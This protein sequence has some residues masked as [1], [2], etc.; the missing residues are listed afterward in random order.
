MCAQGEAAVYV[1]AV[2]SREGPQVGFSPA[3]LAQRVRA[4]LQDSSP[5]P[6]PDSWRS[7]LS[8]VLINIDVYPRLSNA[9]NEFPSPDLVRFECLLEDHPE[10][11]IV[12]R[13]WAETLDRDL[14]VTVAEGLLFEFHASM[15][16]LAFAKHLDWR[17]RYLKTIHVI[18]SRTAIA[19]HDYAREVNWRRPIL[20]VSILKMA[21]RYHRGLVMAESLTFVEHRKEFSGRLGVASVLISRFESISKDDAKEAV[22]ALKRSIDQ[23]NDPTLAT[24]YLLEALC[25]SY[26]LTGDKHILEEALLFVDTEAQRASRN[27]DWHLAAVEILLRLHD[28]ATTTERRSDLLASAQRMLAVSRSFTVE[29]EEKLRW[30]VL[31]QIVVT[32]NRRG[33]DLGVRGTRFPF[34]FRYTS[35]NVHVVS[36]IITDLIRVVS[37]LAREGE[38]LARG[39]YA[40]LIEQA[41]QLGGSE[42]T[43][44]RLLIEMR[45]SSDRWSA[46]QDERSLLLTARDRLRLARLTRD[47]KLRTRALGD[48]VELCE[49]PTCGIAA[50]VLIARDVEDAGGQT[51][52]PPHPG[53]SLETAVCDLVRAGD[54][55][56][57]LAHAAEDALASPD[58]SVAPLGGRSVVV[59]VSD[60]FDV[61]G[62]TFVFKS[63]TVMQWQRELVRSELLRE[64]LKQEGLDSIFGVVDH[65]S[66]SSDQLSAFGASDEVSTVRRFESGSVL[67][68]FVATLGRDD[69]VRV[70]S[71]AARFLGHVHSLERG[72][73]GPVRVRRDVRDKEVG[74]WLRTIGVVDPTAT[75]DKY[76]SCYAGLPAYRRRDA[77]PLNWLVVSEARILAVDLEATGWR[78]LTYE[79]AQLTEDGHLVAADDWEGRITVLSSY[80][81]ALGEPLTEGILGAFEASVL[82]R[83]LRN[84]TPPTGYGEALQNGRQVLS[85]LAASASNAAVRSVAQTILEAWHRQRGLPEIDETL[86]LRISDGRRRRLSRTMSYH[87]RHDPE[88]PRDPAGW[89]EASVLA[90]TLGADVRQSDVLL[91]A[92]DFREPRFEIDGSRVRALYGHSRAIDVVHEGT[93]S[94]VSLFHATELVVAETV[95]LKQG[96]KPMGR[97]FVHLSSSPELAVASGLRHGPMLLLTAETNNLPALRHAAESTYVAPRV[98]GV[99]LRVVPLWA[100]EVVS[101]VAS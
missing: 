24:P 5:T 42:T 78:P 56:G 93:T 95:L 19:L 69:R 46:M 68:E 57:L 26:D 81:E 21:R 83:N 74:R 82:G 96:L 84:L 8:E 75:F 14:A 33:G 48:L 99:H 50:T 100:Y 92:S 35:Q 31:N 13:A 58:L 9:E 65:L 97:Q 94:D 30:V 79:V 90:R 4:R 17:F 80:L 88:L 27:A 53:S 101:A 64:A 62:G 36:S 20:F 41:T 34:G 61:V 29:V 43:K 77:H 89:T 22:A 18:R 52:T 72:S 7:L 1:L 98:A 60:Y 76:W 55:R 3:D 49:R 63:T 85:Y 23:G 66:P 54:F 6:A 12:A 11:E 51:L 47:D 16:P 59:T 15:N 73:D 45:G 67:S 32:G 39:I 10:L 38:P 91:V 37:P 86:N 40:D 44:L 2:A 70:V 25:T 87:L 28:E 71:V